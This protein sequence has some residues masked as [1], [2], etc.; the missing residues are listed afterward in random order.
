MALPV[1][2]F[3]SAKLPVTDPMLAVTASPETAPETCALVAVMDAVLLA[4]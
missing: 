3:T 4:S 1:P 2:T